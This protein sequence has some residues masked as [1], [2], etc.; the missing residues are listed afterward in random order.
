MFFSEIYNEDG[1]YKS[2]NCLHI[3]KFNIAE[4]GYIVLAH[5]YPFINRQ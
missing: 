5:N 4:I 3:S 2:Y 1:K